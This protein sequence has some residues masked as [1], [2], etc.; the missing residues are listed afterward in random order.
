[1]ET[2]GRVN[3]FYPEGPSYVHYA[4]LPDP[5]ALKIGVLNPLN[6]PRQGTVIAAFRD[7]MAPLEVPFESLTEKDYQIL[8]HHGFGVYN[9]HQMDF[10]RAYRFSPSRLYAIVPLAILKR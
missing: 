1:M 5:N 6:K 2:F 4:N 9:A 10:D 8:S 3:P 7:A